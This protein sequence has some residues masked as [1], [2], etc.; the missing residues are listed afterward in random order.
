MSFIAAALSRRIIP[1]VGEVEPRASGLKTWIDEGSFYV[2][3]GAAP[4][5]AWLKNVSLDEFV[6]YLA[7]DH[8]RFAFSSLESRLFSR[9]ERSRPR[10]IGWS[11]LKMYY[12]AFFGA[13]AM[14]RATGLSIA[15]IEGP[16]AKKLTEIAALYAPNANFTPGTYEFRLVQNPDRTI[17]ISV[18]PLSVTGGAHDQFWRAF[19]RFLSEVSTSVLDANEPD[20]AATA[21]EVS[22]I[23][24]VM[25]AR[26]FG[27]GTWL[28]AFRNQINYQHEMKVWF[29]YGAPATAVQAFS[30][31]NPAGRK[32]PRLDYNPASEAIEA[33]IACCQAVGEANASLADVIRGQA[34]AN[35]FD[36]LWER[37]ISEANRTS[38]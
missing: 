6:P 27:S 21:G 7:Y 2:E 14:M 20:A 25:A 12:S 23:Q 33:F 24:K 15:R 31:F 32:L 26:G 11:L 30:K 5:S 10:A 18:L 35:R 37:L 36:R 8:Q 1:R 3:L 16:H 38:A 34:G 13:H 22:D 9:P 17:D 28:S 29:P 19:Y 4:R